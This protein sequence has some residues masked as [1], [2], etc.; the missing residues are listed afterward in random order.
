M[1]RL[2]F[3]VF[4]CF[5]FVLIFSG[6]ISVEKGYAVVTRQVFDTQVAS[7]YN[8]NI[9]PYFPKFSPGEQQVNY[10][11]LKSADE[12]FSIRG[13]EP[14]ITPTELRVA[15]LSR[16]D[17]D[18][19][20]YYT[21]DP[22]G[23]IKD[24][25]SLAQIAVR[26][27]LAQA[28]ISLRKDRGIITS[29]EQE[30]ALRNAVSS[31]Q[32]KE[33]V[34]Q[35]SIN[36]A[37]C[38]ISQL[39]NLLICASQLVEWIIK[40]IIL[41]IAGFLAWLSANLFNMA[42]QV[43][44]LDFAKWAPNALYLIW[45][46]VRQIISLCVVFAGL[47]LGF[48]YIIGGEGE[49]KFKRYL[50]WVMIFALFVNFSYPITRALIDVSNVISLNVYASA[51]GGE[52]LTGSV[53][54]S[55]GALILSRLGLQGLVLSATAVQNSSAGMIGSINGIPGALLA[56]VFVLYAAYILFMLAGMVVFR[57]A[58]LVAITIGS[59][60]LFV[61]SVIPKLGEL[62]MKLR[63]IF[64]GQLVVAP[65][66]M[67]M[68]ALTLKFLDVFQKSGALPS[69]AEL[70]STAG[71][72]NSVVV[73]FNLL[74]MLIMLHIMLKVTKEVSGGVG[75]GVTKFMG[76]VGGFG[77][78]VASAG[79]GLLARQ[80]LGRIASG[81]VSG[82]GA[83]GKWMSNN[84]HTMLGRGAYNLS[85]SLAKST[86]DARNVGLLSGVLN[87]AGMGMGAGTNSSFA[88]QKEEQQKDLLKRYSQ[89]PT[90]NLD[91]T[92]NQEGIAAKRRFR[93]TMGSK[94]GREFQIAEKEKEDTSKRNL[95]TYTLEE[96]K[97]RQKA[98]Y[99]EKDAD[100]RDEMIGTDYEEALAMNKAMG[101]TSSQ[102]KGVED[103]TDYDLP[104][105]QRKG[106][107]GPQGEFMTQ[108]ERD[109]LQGEQI[110]ATTPDAF[111]TKDDEKPST[112]SDGSYNFD[113][114]KDSIVAKST[115][116]ENPKTPPPIM[117]TSS[118]KPET[119]RQE[120]TRLQELAR[121]RESPP[122]D[123]PKLAA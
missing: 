11:L 104:A 55:A 33:G 46:I 98:Y 30:N 87:K 97:E 100:T 75:E 35:L 22:P 64:F 34:D 78:G 47:Y 67:I 122:E 36:A 10:T 84:Q 106:R 13:N 108:G 57:T 15:L 62:A 45:V 24:N 43:G 42:I 90:R 6:L 107:A 5:F 25:L 123:S 54:D 102:G 79:T 56:V 60:L 91:G 38:S 74:M 39:G 118:T 77:L 44:I 4:I 53:S 31:N 51:F 71:S 92:I 20:D 119:R 88:G 117:T 48:M 121:E 86:Y 2:R 63:K 116:V 61:D 18:I 1:K 37:A 23:Q 81:A 68:L 17:G 89:I 58:A 73:F 96:G 109:F 113:F 16:W 14:T 101:P 83:F 12:V 72:G 7:V 59:P 76:Q 32:T 19:Y 65:V 29:V 120:N 70:T 69:G 114:S 82:E 50:P 40:T 94:M 8:A 105:Y 95:S 85:N 52:A 103:T 26:G 99:K 111:S 115:A 41:N 80:T 28:G 93:E 21:S 66:M 110:K 49:D 112:A 9:L 27:A 3:Y